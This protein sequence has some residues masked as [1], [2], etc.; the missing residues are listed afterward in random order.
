MGTKQ[1]LLKMIIE[2]VVTLQDTIRVNIT[3]EDIHTIFEC[4]SGDNV[5]RIICQLN[6]IAEFLNGIPDKTINQMKNQYKSIF[7]KFLAEQS[8]RFSIVRSGR[9]KEEKK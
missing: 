2:K 4:E 7:S 9:Y 3:A 8:Q 6:S 5:N 1:K